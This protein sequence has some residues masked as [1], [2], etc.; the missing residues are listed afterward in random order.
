MRSTRSLFLLLSLL[1]VQVIFSQT[2]SWSK[3]ASRYQR[4]FGTNEG[5]VVLVSAY[6]ESGWASQNDT[7]VYADDSGSLIWQKV[8]PAQMRITCLTSASDSGF[9]IGGYYGGSFQFNGHQFTTGTY[10]NGLWVARCAPDGSFTWVRSASCSSWIQPNGITCRPGIIAV[11]GLASD[12]VDL[13]GDLKVLP[14]QTQAFAATLSQNGALKDIFY[15]QSTTTVTGSQTAHS[16]A[17]S[18]GCGLDEN[19]SV[20]LMIRSYGQTLVDSFK[21]GHWN[22]YSDNEYGPYTTAIIKF[23]AHL[24]PQRKSELNSCNYFC[25]KFKNFRV[26]SKGDC[27]YTRT[28]QYAQSGNDDLNSIIFKLNADGTEGGKFEISQTDRNSIGDLQLDKCERLIFTGFR[29]DY[30]ESPVVCYTL[31]VAQLKPDLS[32][33]W[34]YEDKTCNNTLLGNSLVILNSGDSFISGDFSDTLQLGSNPALVSD[35]GSFYARI[36]APAGFQCAGSVGLSDRIVTNS[37]ITIFPNPT[38]ADFMVNTGSAIQNISIYDI[39]GKLRMATSESRVSTAN[40]PPGIYLVKVETETA[41][42]TTRLIVT[43]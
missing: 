8:L 9:L 16:M 35:Y 38:R 15:S 17:F 23:D 1:C 3:P 2:V 31:I 20:Y 18:Q 42:S 34:M 43:K 41:N 25:N 37:R 29:R 5:N 32:V 36:S 7:L 40:L 27:Y 4:A 19:G 33:D 10:K 14:G 30:I 39:T 13:M 22:E 12:S 24:K 21:V 6:E 28:D 26:N 11:C